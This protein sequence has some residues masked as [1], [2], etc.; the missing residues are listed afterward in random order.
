MGLLDTLRGANQTA[1]ETP[2]AVPAGVIADGA[3]APKTKE[4]FDRYRDASDS[5]IRSIERGECHWQHP[6]PLARPQPVNGV[7][8][9][10]Y[11][12]FN[13]LNLSMRGYEDPRWC[14][15]DQ[16]AKQGW[17]VRKGEKGTSILLVQTR[18]QDT[19]RLDAEGEP[20]MRPYPL[21][22]GHRVFN[23]GQLDG[24]AP[25]VQAAPSLVEIRNLVLPIAEA[26]GVEI[27]EVANRRPGYCREDDVVYVRP[28]SPTVDERQHLGDVLNGLL[29]VAAGEATLRLARASDGEEGQ[30]APHR[31]AQIQ[32][33]I[34]M[35]RAML[36]MRT[37]LP[38]ATP[39]PVKDAPLVAALQASKREVTQASGDAGAIVRYLLAFNPEQVPTLE[40]EHREAMAQAV[41]AG[42]PDDIFDASTFDFWHDERDQMRPSP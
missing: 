24:P 32:L 28:V 41:G 33:R 40:Q 42:A 13:V 17:R 2:A 18:Y 38:L 23:F 10:P 12:G 9:R 31:D 29:D 16:A 19:G 1:I 21:L 30:A 27:Q 7:T 11:S 5:L 4:K 26:M 39:A 37:G 8:G 22:I 36:S 20:V 25:L 6:A 3:S 35:A 14:T 34:E 15:F